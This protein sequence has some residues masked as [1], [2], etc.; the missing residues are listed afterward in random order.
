MNSEVQIQL[1]FLFN[2]LKHHI[3]YIKEFIDESQ[4]SG[5]ETP[6]E[7][8]VKSIKH[9]GGSVMDVYTGLLPVKVILAEVA[10]YLKKNRKAEK[11]PFS[12]WAGREKNDFRVIELSDRSQW[13]AKFHDSEERYVH[14]FPARFSPHSFRVKAN[15]LKSA[16]LYNICIGKDYI[17]EEDLNKARALAGL[18][19][20]K[21]VIDSEAITEMIEILR[22]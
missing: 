15:T 12:S 17:T 19:P 4:F 7:N 10:A 16:I 2:P 14:L 5:K 13:T 9:I 20:V 11:I 21:D 6:D 8:T 18:S 22:G 1:P 3:T